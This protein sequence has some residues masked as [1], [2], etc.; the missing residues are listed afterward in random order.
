MV[1]QVAEIE[2][3]SEYPHSRDP[4]APV[5][6]SLPV[7]SGLALLTYVFWSLLLRDP[8]ARLERVLEIGSLLFNGGEMD[9]MDSLDKSHR[10]SNPLPFD[11]A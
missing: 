2:A 4:D 1:A 11:A 6:D 3:G 5:V 8:A 9:L 7:A 10:L